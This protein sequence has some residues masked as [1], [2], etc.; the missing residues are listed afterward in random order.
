MQIGL[1]KHKITII[2]SDFNAKVGKGKC[3]DLVGEH[4]LGVKNERGDRI[5]L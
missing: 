3:G 1:K 4:D 5:Y 2:M